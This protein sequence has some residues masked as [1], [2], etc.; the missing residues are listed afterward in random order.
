[1]ENEQQITTKRG[2]FG[3]I[4]VTIP[5]TIKDTMLNWW[6]KSGMKK[7]EFFRTAL[8]IGTVQLAQQLGVKE[9]TD[10]NGESDCCDLV[11]Q[12]DHR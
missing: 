5:M 8:M 6:K 12:S 9:Q 11:Q 10:N 3:F 4:R 7:A 1:M 2:N